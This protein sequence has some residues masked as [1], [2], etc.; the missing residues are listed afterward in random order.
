MNNKQQKRNET[1]DCTYMKLNNEIVYA[2]VNLDIFEVGYLHFVW[3]MFN[4]KNEFVF[5]N[6]EVPLEL[7]MPSRPKKAFV[8][9][10]DKGSAAIFM[11]HI[12]DCDRTYHTDKDYW[13]RIYDKDKEK[14][15]VA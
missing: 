9:V 3:E 2:T 8:K 1:R 5:I 10:E 11:K 12:T 7:Q 15:G 6:K 13:L 14:E 4:P